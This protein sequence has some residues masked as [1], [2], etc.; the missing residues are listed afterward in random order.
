MAN[1]HKAVSISMAWLA[2]TAFASH[3]DAQTHHDIIRGSVTTDS[4][5]VI[6]N[7]DIIVTMAPMRASRATKTDSS[8]RYSIDYAAG[9]GDYLVHIAAVG[10]STFRKRVTRAGTDSV[11]TV[12]AKLALAGVQ[13]LSTVQ[14]TAEKPKPWRDNGNGTEPGASEQIAGGVNGAVSPDQAGNLAA[15]GATIPGV[16]TTP[17]G[18]SVGGLSGGQNSTTLNGMAFA[19]ADI[20]RAAR[21][22]VRVTS[23]TYDPSRGWFGGLNENVELSQG[24]LFSGRSA[25]LTIDAPALQYTD[26][27]SARMGQRFSNINADFGGTGSVDEDKYAYNY[28][29]HV[30]RRSSDYVSLSGAAPDLLQRAGVSADSAERLFNILSSAG[31]PL[32]LR[33][34]PSSMISQNAS[35][36]ARFDHAAYDWTTFAQA[37]TTWGL[38][39]YAKVSNDN[40]AGITPTTTT[41]HGGS[42]S[43]VMGALQA[44]FSTYFRD[45]Y[46]NEER[47]AFSYSRNRSDPFLALPD[48]RVLV[49]SSFPDGTGG[50]TSLGFGGNSSM[51]GETRQWM[52]ETTSET[53]FYARGKSTHRVKVNAD[54][55]LDG[56]SQSL[57]SNSLGTFAFNSLADLANNNP[58]SFTR[59]LNAPT[60]TGSVWNGFAAIGDLW[61]VSSNFQIMYGARLEGNRFTSA[62]AFNPEVQSTF[63]LR[64]DNAPNTMHISPRIGFTWIRI[65]Q[66]YD[67]AMSQVGQ[68]RTGPTSYIRGG[69]GEFRNILPA[70]L[71]TNASIATGLPS[72]LQSITCVGPATPTPDWSQYMTDPNLIPTQCLGGSTP[73]FSDAAPAV[74]LFDPAY[75]APR[76]WR[77][78]LAYSSAYRKYFTYSLEGLY[79]LN[80]NQAGRRDVNFSNNQR[81]TLGDEGRPVFVD[82]TSI[83]S[84]SGAIS[85]VDARVSPL[86]GHVI[87]NVS[88]LTSRSKQVT[89][90]MS[91]LLEGISN[92]YF[93]FNYTLA[94]TRA[95]QS[96]FD[97]S[98]FG[99][100]TARNWARG[101]LDIRHQ[102]LLQGG[103]AFK[104]VSLTFFGRLQSGLPFTPMVGGDVNGDGFANDRAFIFNPATM[105]DASLAS[106]TRTLL[107]S[108]SRDVRSCL[109][110]QFDRAAQRNSCE[111]P[112]TTALNAQLSYGGIM[113]VTHNYGTISLA[114]SNPLGGLDQL[115]HGSDH[116]RGWGT[117]AYPD[118]VLYSPQ[119]FDPAAE[120]FKYVINPRFGDTRPTNTL[121]R[122][123]FRATLD[124][125]LNVGR[126]IQQQ[127][128]NRWIM[129]G[130][131]GRKGPKLS[132]KELVRRYSRNVPDPYANIIQES[133]SLLI[134]R[135]QEE[136]LQ[137]ADT[138]YLQRVDSVW[139][140]LGAYLASLPDDF[141]SAD[142]L[143]HQEAAV[144]AGWEI[145]RLDVQRTLPKI[146]SPIQLR[147][148]PGFADMLMKAKE[149]IGIRVFAGR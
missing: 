62:P 95:R 19:G 102:L 122:S 10:Y 61:R 50:L 22:D 143:K 94:D 69:I 60:L 40:A 21:T 39:A 45:G 24:S 89:F 65:P 74:Q 53:Q 138:A 88:T 84:T 7:A 114:L 85:T 106:A 27:V 67:F 137:K 16:A 9:T 141:N 14:V 91:P 48:G 71:L 125:S 103:Y 41:A 100:P 80:L 64:T 131:G 5:K 117:A 26:P 120:R 109:T 113:P 128:L 18:L 90:S 8:G 136:A 68:F 35:F 31:V 34:V 28:G 101:D 112:W 20:P 57:N 116:L 86:F 99:S 15:I 130:R 121:L 142:A 107:S 3:A 104:N 92:W 132:A 66:S 123:P 126:S 110:S 33:G 54:S 145:A 81:F 105:N 58:S 52:W 79:S 78:N 147:M 23:S 36:I 87:D 97:G 44:L 115:L 72:G 38:L 146:L 70:N 111:G 59:S 149:K 56:I 6:P 83:V 135:D 134:T 118:P 43:Q 1:W 42:S 30:G 25:D 127:Q 148:L 82:P 55:R 119:G 73:A 2:I 140:A 139:Q 47:S 133:D 98:T 124:I 76:S 12:D 93:A 144:D 37:K 96:G 4:G 129:P 32:R 29:L 77:G 51:L 46:L 11:F 49:A 13:K 108:A 75:T 63:G 17:G